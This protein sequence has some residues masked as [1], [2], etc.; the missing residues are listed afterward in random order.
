MYVA[1]KERL[2]EHE[3]TV[4]A[5]TRQLAALKAQYV[6]QRQNEA[7]CSDEPVHDDAACEALYESM[8]ALQ[9]RRLLQTFVA[10]RAA[11]RTGT[12]ETILTS[13]GVCATPLLS[14]C[15][16][17]ASSAEAE[18]VDVLALLRP[19][20]HLQLWRT[21]AFGRKQVCVVCGEGIGRATKAFKCRS[22]GPGS[23]KKGCGVVCHIACRMRLPLTCLDGWEGETE[24]ATQ[25]TAQSIETLEKM[26]ESI[27]ETGPSE[28]MPMTPGDGDW[29]KVLYAFEASGEEGEDKVSVK[30][31]EEVRLIRVENDGWALV[32]RCGD[33][34]A[35]G[36]VPRNY[37]APLQGHNATNGPATDDDETRSCATEGTL[38]HVR[39]VFA[40]EACSEGELSFDKDDLLHV[41]HKKPDGWWDG[42]RASDCTKSVG[43]FPSNYV[44][45]VEDIE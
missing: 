23:V 28:D 25:P 8:L 42:Y 9:R 11:I 43:E 18:K 39:A 36:F 30:V 33:G 45:V 40:Y 12:L 6:C 13:D 38:C 24:E 19:H 17:A 26:E 4:N 3:D 20:K 7:S 29:F 16:G 15:K 1:V 44:N 10:Q 31:G 21:P 2:G 34:E 27:E 14:R 32:K 35:S 37:L 5:T 22:H 41:I